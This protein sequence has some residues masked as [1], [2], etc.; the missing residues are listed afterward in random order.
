MKRGREKVKE[1]GEANK[2]GC[3]GE[4]GGR[5]RCETVMGTARRGE[6]RGEYKQRGGPEGRGCLNWRRARAPCTQSGR[7]L[8]GQ[9][10]TGNNN[11]SGL[12]GVSAN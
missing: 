8:G 7:L 3:R 6:E 10:R 5:G 9:W 12:A 2:P 1:E 4:G 11:K